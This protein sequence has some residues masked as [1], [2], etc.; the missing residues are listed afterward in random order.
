V[1]ALDIA[2]KNVETMLTGDLLC[3]SLPIFGFTPKCHT[4]LKQDE[5]VAHFKEHFG[6]EPSTGKSLASGQ[7]YICSSLG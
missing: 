7:M 1:K 2:F 3:Y 5:N 6:V 4:G